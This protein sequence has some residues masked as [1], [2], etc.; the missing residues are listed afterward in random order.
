MKWNQKKLKCITCKQEKWHPNIELRLFRFYCQRQIQNSEIQYTLPNWEIIF[1][2][3]SPVCAKNDDNFIPNSRKPRITWPNSF[4]TRIDIFATLIF[5]SEKGI[6]L[7]ELYLY[8]ITY[9]TING[10]NFVSI[11]KCLQML[12]HLPLKL[13]FQYAGV[14]LVVFS[15]SQLRAFDYS[16]FC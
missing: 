15:Q 2:K 4:I 8:S 7:I 1:T 3:Y 16:P 12:C 9:L 11:W 10:E 13:Y 6:L 14:V 5:T